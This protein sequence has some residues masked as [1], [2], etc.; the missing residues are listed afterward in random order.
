MSRLAFGRFKLAPD[1]TCMH[2]PHSTLAA[3]LRRFAVRKLQTL[4]T[5]A[6]EPAM[7]GVFDVVQI[8]QATS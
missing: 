8:T 6:V 7:S 4:H 5:W 1:H 3:V 2:D